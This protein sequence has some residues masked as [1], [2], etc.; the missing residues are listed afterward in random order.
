[1]TTS[2]GEPSKRKK[3]VS[4]L[5]LISDESDGISVVILSIVLTVQYKR[6]QNKE[7]GRRTQ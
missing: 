5:P 6:K 1:V 3:A 2:V 4:P 7:E